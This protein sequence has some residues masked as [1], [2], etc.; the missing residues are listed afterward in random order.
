MSHPCATSRNGWAGPGLYQ[1]PSV[2][3][4]FTIQP[5]SVAFLEQSFLVRQDRQTVEAGS[6]SGPEQQTEELVAPCNRIAV[7][8]DQFTELVERADDFKLPGAPIHRPTLI[9]AL[10]R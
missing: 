1:Y 6:L 4:D 7:G 3:V 9:H 8:T 2:F 5:E 10:R